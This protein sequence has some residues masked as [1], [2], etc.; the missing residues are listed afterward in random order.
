VVPE[1][2]APHFGVAYPSSWV[3]TIPARTL[4]PATSYVFKV[5]YY[6]DKAAASSEFKTL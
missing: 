1:A 2:P 5:R 3:A 4:A 6:P